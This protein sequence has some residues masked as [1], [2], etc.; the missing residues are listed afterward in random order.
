MYI[1]VCMYVC[2]CVC[3]YIYIHVSR[4]WIGVYARRCLRDFTTVCVCVCLC[5]CVC[6]C[7]CTYIG[8]S[9]INTDLLISF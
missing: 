7:V 3:I 5:V 2:V 6:V 8:K 1:Y 9:K 4:V